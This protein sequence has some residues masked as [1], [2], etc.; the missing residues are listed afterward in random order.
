MTESIRVLNAIHC[1][2]GG[3]KSI[4]LREWYIAQSEG[5]MPNLV[6]SAMKDSMSVLRLD[7]TLQPP[8]L[9]SQN[10]ASRYGRSV[11]PPH[12]QNGL[13]EQRVV[14]ASFVRSDYLLDPNVMKSLQEVYRSYCGE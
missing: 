13:H 6:V 3:K 11:V 8:D 9:A 14:D 5:A 2:H 10:L 1:R 4:E 12:H 7:E